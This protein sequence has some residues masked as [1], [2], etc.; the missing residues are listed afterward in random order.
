MRWGKRA[1]FQAMRAEI[2]ACFHA[3]QFKTAAAD[4]LNKR[5]EM[6]Q[7]LARRTADG[8]EALTRQRQESSGVFE[9]LVQ[10]RRS[11]TTA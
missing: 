10:M 8:D 9:R 2:H 5:Q 4:Y 6:D 11:R 1:L 3:G 7:Y